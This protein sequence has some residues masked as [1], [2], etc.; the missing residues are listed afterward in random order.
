MC[1][2]DRPNI[3][4]AN[5]ANYSENWQNT[6]PFYGELMDAPPSYEEIMEAPPS[7]EE[8]MDP[9]PQFWFTVLVRTIYKNCNHRR[10]VR[11][12]ALIRSPA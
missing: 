10:V 2:R 9:H 4:F 11:S 3:L 6:T 8:I 1:I 7:Y 12:R 5:V